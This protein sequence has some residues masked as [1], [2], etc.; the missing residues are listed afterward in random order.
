MN[1]VY[2]GDKFW[3][4]GSSAFQLVGFVIACILLWRS[5]K[6]YKHGKHVPKTRKY[7]VLFFS[8][9][10]L[11]SIAPNLAAICYFVPGCF[12]ISYLAPIGFFRALIFVLGLIPWLYMYFTK[13]KDVTVQG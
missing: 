2:V 4:T 13:E 8:T 12:Q 6:E 5:W 7:L 11:F 1:T 3:I 10:F 9:M